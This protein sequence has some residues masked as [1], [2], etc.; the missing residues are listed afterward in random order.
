MFTGVN[1]LMSRVSVTE[2]LWI[3][4]VMWCI[5]ESVLSSTTMVTAP[6]A[7]ILS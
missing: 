2:W 7:A 5:A 1:V 6:T 4:V 3:V